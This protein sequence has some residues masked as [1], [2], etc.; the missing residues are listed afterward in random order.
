MGNGLK[1]AEVRTHVNGRNLDDPSLLPFFE[2][3]QELG[4]SNVSRADKEKILGS[5]AGRARPAPIFGRGSG[6]K[7]G[8]ALSTRY[9]THSR[10]R[11]HG[12]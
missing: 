1:G 8:L 12:G 6:R 3:A 5:D 9:F 11:P 4:P 7:W 2:A 10:A